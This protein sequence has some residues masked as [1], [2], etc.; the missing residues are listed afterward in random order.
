M[1]NVVGM[2]YYAAQ[3]KYTFIKF[4]VETQYSD[5]QPENFIIE[6]DK[7]EGRQIKNGQEVNIVVSLGPKMVEIPDVVNKPFNDARNQLELNGFTVIKTE[8]YDENVTEGWVLATDPPAYETRADG[9]QIVVTVSLGPV[10]KETTVPDVQG[11]TQEEAMLMLR[12][13]KLT[14]IVIPYNTT[15]SEGIV[16]SQE[17]DPGTKVER[18]TQIKI[19]VSTG[20]AGENTF[21]LKIL[22]PYYQDGPF[23]E[24]GF[25][26]EA[27]V[28]DSLRGKIKLS[29]E[30][31][32]SKRS[33]TF[34][35]Q[36]S[37][38]ETMLIQVTSD[39]TNKSVE[40]SK[41]EI[42]FLRGEDTN[43]SRNNNAFF[44]AEKG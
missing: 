41:E 28:G 3:N 33:V 2:D 14:P 12:D 30:E 9:S 10:S 42:D 32:N 15:D 35:V 34:D 4:V 13:K 25:L 31:I 7:A 6:Q 23:Y 21:G 37:G 20:T 17:I 11:L 38:V 1:P 36:G 18:N 5:E 19:A 39:L 16:V 29:K 40:Y 22:I 8:K 24:G 27:Y 43:I 26:I 44:N